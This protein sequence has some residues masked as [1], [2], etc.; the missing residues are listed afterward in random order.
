MDTLYS[1]NELGARIFQLVDGK[2]TLR[3]LSFLIAEE[4]ELPLSEALDEVG[5]FVEK[6]VQVEAIERA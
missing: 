2:R 4:F 5:S 3:Q 1:L 6:L